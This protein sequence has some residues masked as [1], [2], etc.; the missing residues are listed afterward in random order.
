[1]SAGVYQLFPTA[2]SGSSIAAQSN[3]VA[4]LKSPAAG[5][6]LVGGNVYNPHVS[7]IAVL[8]FFDAASGD[9]TLGGTTPVFSIVVPPGTSMVWDPPRPIRCYTGLSV[10]AVDAINGT[11]APTTAISLFVS[12]Y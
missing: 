12:Y 7:D 1:M 4:D 9:V 8:E 6:W 3:T 2:P 10:V 11:A 5:G